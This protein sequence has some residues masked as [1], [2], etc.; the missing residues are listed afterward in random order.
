MLPLVIIGRIVGREYKFILG[1]KNELVCKSVKGKQ[2]QL[3]ES[4]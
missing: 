1:G 3:Y 2:V 4:K